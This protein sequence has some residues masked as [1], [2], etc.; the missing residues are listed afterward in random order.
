MFDLTGSGPGVGERHRR[1]EPAATCSPR[2]RH[3]GRFGGRVRVM[4]GLICCGA[5]ATALLVLSSNVAPV[6]VIAFL[7]WA[8]TVVF[9]PATDSALPALVSERQLVAA[10]SGIWTA[11]VL[12]QATLAPAAGAIYALL[13]P[14]PAFALNTVSGRR[15][16]APSAAA[17]RSA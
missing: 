4:V 16:Q 15:A 11:A 8:G 7:L 13:G 6:Y 14:A 9:N 10:Y 3:V 12:S 5:L 2:C 1:R 17:S